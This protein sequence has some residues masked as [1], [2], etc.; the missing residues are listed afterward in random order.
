MKK[1]IQNLSECQEE[2]PGKNKS[3]KLK[4]KTSPVGSEYDSD[5]G[6]DCAGEGY[7]SDD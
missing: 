1:S 7:N 6:S 3:K 5:N 2:Y 4:K